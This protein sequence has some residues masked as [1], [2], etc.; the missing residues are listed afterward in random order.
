ML[1]VIFV[2]AARGDDSN[3]GT[4]Q[5]PL[6]TLGRS[7]LMA[8]ST[9]NATIL[10]RGGVYETDTVLIDAANNGLTI[11][12]YEGEPVTVSGGRAFRVPRSSWRPYIQRQGWDV[13]PNQNNVYGQ[14]LSM[15]DT[16][17]VKFLGKFGSAD[18][19]LAA[20][21]ADSL[22]KGPFR[23]FTFHLPSFSDSVFRSQC[24]GR[25]DD[26]QESVAQQNVTSGFFISQNT[27][28]AD[29]SPLGITSMPGLRLDGKRLIRAKYAWRGC[30]PRVA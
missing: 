3:P 28:V 6:R 1:Q 11:Q 25:T 19:C 26:V 2:D 24:F 5:Q 8:K 27:W 21:K 14:A 18:E 22:R 30:R 13:Q 10:L 9:A 17:T 20:A 12:N 7:V 16:E 4:Q 29:L 15:A 23:S